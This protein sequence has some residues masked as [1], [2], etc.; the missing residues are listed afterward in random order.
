M[1]IRVFCYYSSSWIISNEPCYTF[2]HFFYS[3]SCFLVC[4]VVVYLVL[5]AVV[6]YYFSFVLDFVF[7]IRALCFTIFFFVVCASPYYSSIR[8]IA[9]HVVTAFCMAS[10]YARMTFNQ[11]STLIT[12]HAVVPSFPSPSHVLHFSFFLLSTVSY[13]Y[14]FFSRSLWLGSTIIV[15]W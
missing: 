3:P 7:C 15:F 11:V 14:F 10:M 1:P 6:A 4:F 8:K 9:G 12:C 13:G 5:F 2:R